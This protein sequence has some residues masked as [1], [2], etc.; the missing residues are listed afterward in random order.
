MVKND[1]L[2]LHGLGLQVV[3]FPVSMGS[4]LVCFGQVASALADTGHDA[5]MYV[6]SNSKPPQ[7][8]SSKVK[9]VFYK[10]S[11]VKCLMLI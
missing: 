8:V 5:T 1:G 9:F 6:P 2:L 4:H 11:I 10:V 3:L 7:G